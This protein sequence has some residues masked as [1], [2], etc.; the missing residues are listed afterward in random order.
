MVIANEKLAFENKE[1]T[2]RAEELVIANEKLAF[3]NKEKTARADELVIANE[4]VVFENE[5]KV[6]R[7][8]ELVVAN[9]KIKLAFAKLKQNALEL[10]EAQRLAHLGSW[11]LDIESSKVTWTEELYRMYG[12]SPEEP[13][14]LITE[15]QKL[16]T[17][18]SWDLLDS[19]MSNTIN[20]GISYDLELEI[21]RGDKSNGWIWV[22]GEAEVNAVGVISGL[23]AMIQDISERKQSEEEKLGLERQIQH[24]QKLESLGVLAGGIAHDFNNLVAIILGNAD[25]ALDGLSPHSPARENLHEIEV[26]SRRGADLAKQMLAYSGK[27]MFVVEPVDLGEFVE[28]M[29][30]LLD[31][32]IS[33]KAVLKY[34]FAENLPTFD[35]DAT[36]IRQ[37]IMNLIINASEAIGDR[38]GVIALSTGAMHCDPAYLEGTELSFASGLDEPLSESLYVYL[39]VTDTGSGMTSETIRKI[40]D[41]FFTT[42]FAG[43]GLGMSATM[44]IM[45]GHK[46]GI[47]IYSELGKGTTFKMLFPANE[48]LENGVTEKREESVTTTWQ[49]EGTILIVDD[50]EAICA[51]GRNMVERMGFTA[52]TAA[53]GREAVEMFREHRTEIVCVLLDLTM[54]HMD[55]E[56]AFRELRR[57]Q[58]DV[59]VI[60]CSGY[61]MQ[62]A[63]QRFTGKGLADFLEKPY[64]MR[65]LREKLIKLLSSGAEK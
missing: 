49:G 16:F 38:S 26:A 53:D 46:G 64:Q 2:A 12:F 50:E 7:A 47:K 25:L 51:M 21:V 35:G 32:S 55:G 14:P 11:H 31:V 8:G 24:A 17:P 41:P 28:E 9:G 40:F 59:K 56:E 37:V 1:K 65:K 23:R 60:L 13:V 42:K 33:K 39:E 54:P 18:K 4:K 62:D 5:E 61:N 20:T 57:I 63:T 58:P 44:G 36:Q 10:N 27:G 52:L 43:R 45:R 29:G 15:S 34:N 6:A 19:A 30:H 48:L 3:E 22:R